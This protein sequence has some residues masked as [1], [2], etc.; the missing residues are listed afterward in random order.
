MGLVWKDTRRE[1]L[2]LHIVR[3]VVRTLNSLQ[4][5]DDR[6]PADIARAARHQ[7]RFSHAPAFF[8]AAAIMTLA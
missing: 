1:P 7:N 6:P 3:T 4:K 2:P 5:L 8:R